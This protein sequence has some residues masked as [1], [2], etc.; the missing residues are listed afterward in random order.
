MNVDLLND[1]EDGQCGVPTLRVSGGDL[2]ESGDIT[3]DA[4]VTVLVFTQLTP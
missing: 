2:L 3:F 1:L 4:T